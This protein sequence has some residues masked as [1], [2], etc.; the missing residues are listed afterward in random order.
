MPFMQDK[1]PPSYTVR[2][3]KRARRIL[4]KIKA[5]GLEVVIP[6]YYK[7]VHLL[8]KLI[9]EQKAWI[10]RHLRELS[11]KDA[12]AKQLPRTINLCAVNR[13]VKIEYIAAETKLK[14]REKGEIDGCSIA[15]IGNIDEHEACYA[16]LKDWLFTQ[17][18]H[19]LPTLLQYY[20]RQCNLTYEK[21]AIKRQKTRWGSCSI[22]KSINL[23]YQLLL[24]PEELTR[25]V[26]IHELCHTKELNHSLRFWH[27][28]AS[29]E[30][31]WQRI[32]RE[33]LNYKQFIPEWF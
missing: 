10:V 29:F 1:W 18:K 7:T 30:P 26:I 33:L 28:V 21:V 16:L 2:R 23:N 14:L 22:N 5:T 3:S 12:H 9:I 17:A 27:L 6:Y 31:N 24:L 19:Y 4:L 13:L 8:P 15:V 32:K 11:Q 25:Y 20:S